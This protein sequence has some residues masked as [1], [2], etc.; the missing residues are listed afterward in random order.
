MLARGFQKNVKEIW[1]DKAKAIIAICKSAHGYEEID[2]A[3]E[4]VNSLIN[5]N[6]VESLYSNEWIPHYLDIGLL[7][8]NM[9]DTYEITV[10]FDTVNKEFLCT[11]WGDMVENDMKRFDY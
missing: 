1:P 9:G 6:G 11:S 10:I 7:Y 4:A 2:N 3:L 5:G 8:V